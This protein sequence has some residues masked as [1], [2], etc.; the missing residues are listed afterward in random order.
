MV[1]EKISLCITSWN[2]DS[3]TVQAYQHVADDPRIGEIIIV[4]DKSDPA[5]VRGL[6]QK[7]THPKVK[8]FLNQE[9]LG[10]YKNKAYAISQATFDYVIIL[11]SDNVIDHN[12]LNAVFR[13]DWHPY[14]ILAPDFAKPHFDYTSF[15]GLLL[16]KENVRKYVR[17]PKFDCLINT[18]NYFVHRDEYIRVYDPSIEPWTADTIYQNYNWLKSGNKI[19]VVPGMQYFHNVHEKKTNQEGSHYQRYVR[20]TGN[21]YQEIENKLM[22]LR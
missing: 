12:Y 8:L 18:M 11:D 15:A 13:S 4:D 17:K 3:M 20:N 1:G 21:L 6:Q 2:R 10:C 19:Y 7:A 5:Y 9:N 22:E 14:T 16:T